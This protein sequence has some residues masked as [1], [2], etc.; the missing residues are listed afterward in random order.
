MHDSFFLSGE[1]IFNQLEQLKLIVQVDTLFKCLSIGR[2]KVAGGIGEY[3]DGI[4]GAVFPQGYIA[5]LNTQQESKDQA[6]GKKLFCFYIYHLFRDSISVNL[7][8]IKKLGLSFSFGVCYNHMRSVMPYGGLIEIIFTIPAF[9]ADVM[10][11]Y[12]NGHS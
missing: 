9:L 12:H 1:I 10:E 3:A 6:H 8:F 2:G 11:V 7:Y 4:R 5:I